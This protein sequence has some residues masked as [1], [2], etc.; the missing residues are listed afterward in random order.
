VNIQPQSGSGSIVSFTTKEKEIVFALS[1][2]T[3]GILFHFLQRKVGNKIKFT[4]EE[5]R[6]R[7]SKLAVKYFPE[8]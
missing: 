8:G 7:I 4:H 6:T 1:D 3:A 2:D 5:H